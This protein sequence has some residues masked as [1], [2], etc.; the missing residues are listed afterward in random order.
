MCE[1]GH[2]ARELHEL[3]VRS[4]AEDAKAVQLPLAELGLVR[5]SGT[6]HG[7]GR[8]EDERRIRREAGEVLVAPMAAEG[9]DK[10][11]GG[12][13]DLGDIGWGDRGWPLMPGAAGAPAA[14]RRSRP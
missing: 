2:I 9:L 1:D 14:N 8:V 11:L 3:V 4:A 12:G 7:R 6:K 13:Q 10:P 5:R